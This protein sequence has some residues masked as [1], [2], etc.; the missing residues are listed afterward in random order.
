MK[1]NE[2]ALQHELKYPISISW[3][4][5]GENGT[6]MNL[7]SGYWQDGAF[8]KNP[9]VAFRLHD[10]D[11]EGDFKSEIAEISNAIKKHPLPTDVMKPMVIYPVIGGIHYGVLVST[12]TIDGIQYGKAVEL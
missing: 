11:G 9:H 2:I 10:L 6:W 1:L 8:V 4:V 12:P 3:K 7:A 5:G